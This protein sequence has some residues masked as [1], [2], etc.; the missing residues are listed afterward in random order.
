[1]LAD[2]V[3]KGG[4]FL[5]NVGA[6]PQGTFPQE[7]LERLREIGDWMA[8]NAEAIHGTRAVAPFRERNVCFT[9]KGEWVYAIVLAAE[10]RARPPA[11]V[12]LSAIVPAAGSEVR[13]LGRDKPL[14]W[15]MADGRADP[16]VQGPALPARLGA[17]VQAEHTLTREWASQAGNLRNGSTTPAGKE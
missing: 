2:I 8:V 4:N 3:C 11:R 1:M 6:S 15:H 12:R 9:R 13:L 10:D 17:E 7:A 16:A 5:L 14:A